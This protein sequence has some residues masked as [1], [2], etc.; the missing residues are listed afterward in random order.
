MAAGWLLWTAVNLVLLASF[1]IKELAW[2]QDSLQKMTIVASVSGQWL[3]WQLRKLWRSLGPT[4]APSPDKVRHAKDALARSVAD[5]WQNEAAIRGLNDPEPVPILWRTTGRGELMDHPCLIGDGG[6]LSGGSDQMADFIE[7]FRGLRRCRLVILGA[8]GTGKSTLAIQMVLELLRTRREDDPVPVLA[9]A[10]RWDVWAHPRVRDWLPE[11]L[12][13]DYPG[14]R[15][16]EF[17]P[18]MP[19]ALAAGGEVFLVLD[20]LDELPEDARGQTLA[21]LNRSLGE[22]DRL[23]LTCRTAEF[24]QAVHAAEDVLSAATVIEPQP[25]TPE[26]AVQ[27][28]RT[29]LPPRPRHDWTEVWLALSKNTVPCLTELVSTPLGLWLLRAVYIAGKRDPAPLVRDPRLRQM[30]ALR[31]HLYERLIPAVIET[32]PPADTP[33]GPFRP[34]RAWNPDDVRRW[35]SHLALLAR[36]SRDLAWWRIAGASIRPWRVQLVVGAVAGSLGWLLF[37]A[38]VW[39][40]R[41]NLLSQKLPPIEAGTAATLPVGLTIGIMSAVLARDWLKE[42]PGRAEFRLRRR[43]PAGTQRVR[44]QIRQGL[45]FGLLTGLGFGV[46]DILL[47]E[48]LADSTPGRWIW[49]LALNGF[50]FA[51]SGGFALGLIAWTER[52]APTRRASSA[53]STYRAD[54]RLTVVKAGVCGLTAALVFAVMI[55]LMGLGTPYLGRLAI[56]G[57]AQGFVVGLI[58]GLVTGRHHAWLTLAIAVNLPPGTRRLPR[59]LMPFLEDAHRLGLLRAVGPVYQ[60]RHA[61]LQDHLALSGRR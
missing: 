3:S 60:F 38:V 4:V 1:F 17:G 39:G 48:L 49:T 55:G 9:P 51:I 18:D 59:R 13:T 20:G 24:E 32:R 61:E 30:D 58:G 16:D 33:A 21:A 41:G 40:L 28:L 44:R 22:H 57:A 56:L 47:Q 15:E 8:P 29:C 10:S 25:I 52:P 27:Y 34:H 50:V 7:S 42:P 2:V 54:E 46:M 6:E 37:L 12:A 45:L 35:L 26:T 14:L 11:F 23:I 36:R 53:I 43:T 19:D 31:A 5:Q